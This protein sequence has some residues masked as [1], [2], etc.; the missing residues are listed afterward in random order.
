M[1]AITVLAQHSFIAWDM[2]RLSHRGR[3]EGRG[4]EMSEA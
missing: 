4:R 1:R 3:G 2:D